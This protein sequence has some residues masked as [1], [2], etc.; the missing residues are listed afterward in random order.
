MVLAAT[1]AIAVAAAL[2]AVAAISGSPTP[3]WTERVPEAAFAAVVALACG[4]S[5]MRRGDPL[6][7]AAG[8]T[9]G[10]L[11][12]A[13]VAALAFR[14]P[15]RIPSFGPGPTHNRWWLLALLPALAACRGSSDPAT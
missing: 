4:F 3:R 10:A 15:G 11:L 1:T 9:A 5:L 14:W 2:A 12:P 6:G 7:G 8:V 13:L